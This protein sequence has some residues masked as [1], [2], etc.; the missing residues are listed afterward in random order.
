[1]YSIENVKKFAA[2]HRG[3]LG[4]MADQII[5]RAE[6]EADERGLFPEERLRAG[7]GSSE[8]ARDFERAFDRIDHELVA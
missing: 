5:A 6:A 2:Q 7:T 4:T 3:R 8:L 1:M